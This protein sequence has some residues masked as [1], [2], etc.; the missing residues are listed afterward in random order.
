MASAT[1]GRAVWRRVDEDPFDLVAL[2]RLEHLGNVALDGLE[3]QGVVMA[4]QIPQPQR[5]LRIVIDEQAAPRRP[6]DMRG[7]VRR[8]RAFARAA[9]TRC[10]D[11]D[12]HANAP[13]RLRGTSCSKRRRIAYAEKAAQPDES[14][15]MKNAIMDR[16]ERCVVRDERLFMTVS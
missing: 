6:V 12:I 4:Q 3:R 15:V 14:T 7:E 5:A 11:Q 13:Q 2:G 9:F 16:C 10:K 1:L 8:E